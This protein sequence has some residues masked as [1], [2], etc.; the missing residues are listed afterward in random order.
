[1]DSKKHVRVDFTLNSLGAVNSVNTC[2][3]EP[4]VPVAPA[5]APVQ[6]AAAPVAGGSAAQT[7]QP[8]KQVAILLVLYSIVHNCT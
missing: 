6:P 2:D 7:I 3:L 5:A 8:F 4:R 1:M